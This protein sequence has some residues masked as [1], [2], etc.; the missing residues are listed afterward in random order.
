[1]PVRVAKRRIADS[2]LRKNRRAP[3]R[4]ALP[5]EQFLNEKR[6]LALCIIGPFL[7]R[8]N[9]RCSQTRIETSLENCIAV[10]R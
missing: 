5:I 3:E 10:A 4:Y 1:M 2:M 7:Q 6:L 8:P 9:E